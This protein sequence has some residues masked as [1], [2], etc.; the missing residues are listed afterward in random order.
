MNKNPFFNTYISAGQFLAIAALLMLVLLGGCTASDSKNGDIA[1]SED[2]N[3][4]TLLEGGNS[5]RCTISYPVTNH[6]MPSVPPVILQNFVSRMT[7]ISLEMLYLDG[8]PG[9]APPYRYND[10]TTVMSSIENNGCR[11]AG[12]RCLCNL[13]YKDASLREIFYDAAGCRSSSV[14]SRHPLYFRSPYCR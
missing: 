2:E 11:V 8:E 3:L 10:L 4:C 7:A 14:H 13:V 1:E 12:D 5:F 9:A 6:C